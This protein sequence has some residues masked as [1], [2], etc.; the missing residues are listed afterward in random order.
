ML[1]LILIVSGRLLGWHSVTVRIRPR[2]RTPLAIGIDKSVATLRII[3]M[4]SEVTF[5]HIRP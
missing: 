5:L 1:V 2:M 3:Q 4:G